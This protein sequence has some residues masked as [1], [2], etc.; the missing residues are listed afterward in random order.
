MQ[1]MV[2]LSTSY[3][4]FMW[5]KY[6]SVILHDERY[7]YDFDHCSVIRSILLTNKYHTES[8][9]YTLSVRYF[10]EYNIEKQQMDYGCMYEAYDKQFGN[11]VTG[12]IYDDYSI[13]GFTPFFDAFI[14]AGYNGYDGPD[15]FYALPVEYIIREVLMDGLL[16]KHRLAG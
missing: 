8:M 13:G 2:N 3:A 15:D 10:C 6:K 4:R 1:L 16:Y 11:I 5:N 14:K 12:K 9:N 7:W